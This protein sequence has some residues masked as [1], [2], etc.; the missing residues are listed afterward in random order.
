[1]AAG[2]AVAP[3]KTATILG[4]GY[5][6][7]KGTTVGLQ[8]LGVAP[9][10]ADLAGDIAGLVAGY[11]AHW[12][13]APPEVRA[14]AE[15]AEQAGP[16][17][18]SGV[19]NGLIDKLTRMAAQYQQS[20]MESRLARELL[21]RKYNID[22]PEPPAQTAPPAA[23]ETNPPSAET[24]APVPETPVSA[25]AQ[26]QPAAE[27]TPETTFEKRAIVPDDVKPG[28][29]F[30]DKAGRTFTVQAINKTGQVQFTDAQ[31]R[32]SVLNSAAQFARRMVAVGA[33]EQAQGQPAG[34]AAETAPAQSPETVSFSPEE[35]KPA[36]PGAQEGAQSQEVEPAVEQASA[37]PQAPV[38]VPEAPATEQGTGNA[39]HVDKLVKAAESE[40]P[41]V[42]QPETPEVSAQNAVEPSPAEVPAEKPEPQ[43]AWQQAAAESALE[44]EEHKAEVVDAIRRGESVPP[45]VLADHPEAAA[46]STSGFSPSNEGEKGVVHEPNQELEA[47]PRGKEVIQPKAETAVEEKPAHKFSSTQVNLPPEFHKAFSA[48]TAS[49]PESDLSEEGRETEPHITA[50]YGLHAEEP[51]DIKKIL[52]KEPPVT[53]KIGKASVFK[54]DD[55]DV[56]KLDIES[57]DLRRIN[58]ALSKLPNSNEHPKYEP[59]LTLAYVK[60]G[61]GT[62]YIG[63]EIPGLTGKTVTFDALTF[64]A[65]DR[66]K[67]DIPLSAKPAVKKPTAKE[68]AAAERERLRTVYTPGNLI[69]T[70]GGRMERVQEFKERP[71]GHFLVTVQEVGPNGQ[72]VPGT[73][74]RSHSTPPSAQARVL[75]HE[76]VTKPVERKA[77]LQ[78]LSGAE[79]DAEKAREALGENPEKEETSAA[80]APPAPVNSYEQRSAAAVPESQPG[81]DD[82][83][84]AGTV[85]IPA[86]VAKDIIPILKKVAVKSTIPILNNVSIVTKGGVTRVVATDL[87]QA[88]IFT[89]PEGSAAGDGAV[90][91]PVS[92]LENATKGKGKENLQIKFAP[93][94][95]ESAPGKAE[96]KAGSAESSASTL[97]ISGYPEL[98][99][100]QEHLGSIPAPALLDAIRKVVSA[101]SPEES[102]FTLNGGL[103]EVVDG[104]ATMVATDGHRLSIQKFDA[105]DLSGAH[106]F[107]IPRRSLE[108]LQKMFAKEPGNLSIGQH[109]GKPPENPKLS[110]Q[111]K[112]RL[113][114]KY[115]YFG[116]PDSTL[117]ARQ[118]S[119]NFP[120]Y[121]RVIPD[122]ANMTHTAIVDKEALLDLLKRAIAMKERGNNMLFSFRP[123]RVIGLKQTEA[124][125]VKGSAGAEVTNNEGGDVGN[126]RIALNAKY[127]EDAIRPIDGNKVEIQLQRDNVGKEGATRGRSNA[128]VVRPPGDASHTTIVMPMRDDVPK[129]DDGY[130]SSGVFGSERG[131]APILTDLIGWTLRAFGSKAKDVDYQAFSEEPEE[132][133][134]KR[135][136]DWRAALRSVVGTGTGL[137]EVRSASLPAWRALV[138]MASV[139]AV[140][141]V[142]LR[143]AELDMNRSLEHAPIKI[144]DLLRYYSESRLRGIRDRW[145]D[146]A[147]QADDMTDKQLEEGYSQAFSNL[148]EAIENKR[149]IPQNIRQTVDALATRKDWDTMRELL[150]QTFWDA[151]GAVSSIMDDD[152]FGR[153][154]DLVANDEKVSDA[155]RIYARSIESLMADYHSEHE[156]VMA[157]ALGPANRYVP[158]IGVI[159]EIRKGVAKQGAFLGI[160]RPFKKPR[161][162]RNLM[163]TGISSH[164]Y[165]VSLEN[166]EKGLTSAVRA[167]SKYQAIDAMEQAGL[168]TKYTGTQPQ[169]FRF[170]G[171]YYPAKRIEISPARTMLIK[172]NGK[173]RS[174]Q[175]PAQVAVTAPWVY[176][177]VKP[178]L[179]AEH[180]D[181]S[182]IQRIMDPANAA[183]VFGPT[184]AIIDSHNILSTLTANTPFLG[185]TL[186][187][188]GLSAPL[189]KRFSAAVMLARQVEP[190]NEQAFDDLIHMAKIGVLPAKYGAKTWS[191]EIAG[192][193]GAQKAK[194]W[195][196]SPFLYGPAGVDVR[197]RLKMYRIAR[198]LNP[199]ISDEKLHDIINQIGTYIPGLQTAVER[200][201]K[202]SGLAPFYTRGAQML[203]NGIR[204]WTGTG[205]LP[206]KTLGLWMASA[207]TGGAIAMVATWLAVS[208][209]AGW[210][211][212][213]LLK[214]Q[215]RIPEHIRYSTLGHELGWDKNG[216]MIVDFSMWNPTVARGARALGILGAVDTMMAGG[217]WWQGTEYG[218][219]QAI[220][221]A[222]QPAI[223]PIP[224]A[225]LV[226]VFGVQPYLTGMRD[227][228]GA[229]SPQLFPAVPP[230]HAGLKSFAE[231]GTAAAISANAM[232]SQVGQATGFLSPEQD[233]G[234]RW[235]KSLLDIAIP[236]A[237][238]K[239]LNL[240]SRQQM[241]YQQRTGTR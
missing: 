175:L 161:N 76:P 159:P 71:D 69:A 72:P 32:T 123:D 26:N 134:L 30:R 202:K 115:L 196:S 150:S 146:F 80:P 35:L 28:E 94:T 109:I 90:T 89:L 39:E 45:E 96:L 40:A 15:A 68:R 136:Y 62:K 132:P 50:L 149:G 201:L 199:D 209:M 105:P 1:M 27:T 138:K 6:A 108:T 224:R 214:S 179:D 239:P 100:Q 212:A 119:G 12:A 176:K 160:R 236:G 114:S 211:P 47:Q 52:K 208:K 4:A 107:L 194:W 31:G 235:L 58:A 44:P 223:G 82:L 171:D 73:R 60:P 189:L 127:I 112:A 137:S 143:R 163:A 153:I 55:Q 5:A 56:V 145:Q 191:S 190:L 170:Q 3:I 29:T 61:E 13:G 41:A 70:E 130:Q 77:A 219:S 240:Y 131:S 231:R 122:Q 174:V 135:H 220:S 203:I 88:V 154:G 38:E 103:L 110:A 147:E 151:A 24:K 178:I 84:K 101:I 233:P 183:A 158:L 14:I 86:K 7:Q 124:A 43:F 111:E 75:S 228:R 227:R 188:K 57:P 53:A 215:V 102:R 133:E 113:T 156:G 33:N 204:S 207:I 205:P 85:T 241:L 63:K 25:E 42:Q 51:S 197:G 20:P 92:A 210:K 128:I 18:E 87:E 98:P 21:K 49:I 155:D 216:T 79:L 186:A 118:L 139:D 230:R 184:L 152:E 83:P 140:T 126:P 106:R 2:A 59:H 165:D 91:L 121:R 117:M 8:K 67:T 182:V 222:L 120:D 169:Y 148:L 99:E 198:A 180:L 200:F 64:S 81:R 172:E 234:G 65:K 187:E 162:E 141:R 11:G 164:G 213:G 48:A 54:G 185:G 177:E 9:E 129:W 19:N 10:Y 142:T 157:T 166:L 206:K 229:L 237:N 36:V 168:L 232:E 78:P 23:P 238:P 66:T 125:T 221:T 225:A 74:P 192:M 217:N 181:D 34:A 173:T 104:K 226:G 22:I 46:E 93:G 16:H 97:A 144:L 17:A 95:V 195:D 167:S 193:S 218:A 37:V 116:R